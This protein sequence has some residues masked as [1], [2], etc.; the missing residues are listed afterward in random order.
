MGEDIQLGG[1][2]FNVFETDWLEQLP[3]EGKPPRV[4]QSKF[5]TIRLTVVNN[6]NKEVNIPF[7]RLEDEAGGSVAELDNGEGVDEWW[8]VLRALPPGGEHQTHRIVFDV[9]PGNY[10]LHL[11]DGG[12]PDS[13]KTAVVSIPFR[14]QDRSL[15]AAPSGS[16]Q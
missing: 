12:E 3:A 15:P 8:G 9:R 16:S 11:S 14:I 13:E 7:M 6:A 4:P 5:L 1:V 2:V 10:F